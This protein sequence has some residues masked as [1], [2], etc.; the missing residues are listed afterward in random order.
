MHGKNRVKTVIYKMDGRLHIWKYSKEVKVKRYNIL[1]RIK[2]QDYEV[3]LNRRKNLKILLRYII[4][5][6]ENIVEEND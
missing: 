2:V 6:I 4:N 5:N 1:W 3:Q